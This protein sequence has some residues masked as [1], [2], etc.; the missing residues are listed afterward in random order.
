MKLETERLF[1]ALL[2]LPQLKLWASDISLLESELPCIYDAE[3]IEGEFLN[4]INGQIKIIENDPLHYR[5]HSFWFIMRKSDGVVVE[6]M[7]FK[8]I[9]SKTKE[10]E[11]GYGLGKK[12]EHNGYMTE[13]VKKFCDWALTDEKIETITA[14][15]EREN[16]ASQGVLERCGFQKYREEETA[17]WKLNRA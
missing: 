11:I 4:I 2:T 3:P 14:E 1:I 12:Y 16:A 7:D 10:I 17:W 5:Y 15:T 9:P 8:N 13:A 6:S